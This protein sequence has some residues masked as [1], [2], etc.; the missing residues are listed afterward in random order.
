MSEELSR[1]FVTNRK[2][3][4]YESEGQWEYVNQDIIVDLP[5]PYIPRA[6]SSACFPERG[7]EGD[8]NCLKSQLETMN[9]GRSLEVNRPSQ[10][11]V[12]AIPIWKSSLSFV[13]GALSPN[14]GAHAGRCTY[15]LAILTL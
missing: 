11:M 13:P 7:C 8:Q 14:S 1:R 15:W 9:R 12:A 4:G 3:R 6:E 5:A 10:N 2:E